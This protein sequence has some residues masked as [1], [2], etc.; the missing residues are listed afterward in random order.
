MALS[1]GVV[2]LIVTPKLNFDPI[3]LPKMVILVTFA[4]GLTAFVFRSV[5]QDRSAFR[6]IEFRLIGLLVLTLFLAFNFTSTHWSLQLWGT[7]GR[8]TGLLT[9]LALLTYSLFA[10]L[11]INTNNIGIVIKIFIRTS[12]IFSIYV[13]LQY[14]ELDPVAWSVNAPVGTLGNINFMSSFL[15]LAS[16]ALTSKLLIFFD[17]LSWSSR[18]HYILWTTLNLIL[19]YSSG[20]IQG[21]AMFMTGLTFLIFLI[22]MRKGNKRIA[23]GVLILSTFSGVLGFLGTLGRGLFGEELQQDSVLFRLDYWKAALRMILDYPLI[24]IGLDG[25]GEFYREYRD[26]VAVNRT[27]PQR[28]TDTAHNVFL[29]LATGGGLLVLTPFVLLIFL[30]SWRVLRFSLSFHS[31]RSDALSLAPLLSGWFVFML[32]SINQ[33]GVGVWGFIFLGASL[34]V[35]RASIGDNRNVKKAKNKVSKIQSTNY[36][37]LLKNKNPSSN[38]ESRLNLNYSVSIMVVSFVTVSVFGL[39]A[40][41]PPLISDFRFNNA[42]KSK[43]VD[44]AI[45]LVNMPPSTIPQVE[46]VLQTLT[47]LGREKEAVHVARKALKRFP[48]NF[49]TNVVLALSESSAKS[50]AARARALLLDIDPQNLELRKTLEDFENTHSRP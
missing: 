41:L 9:Y 47:D 18:I 29:D 35:S 39:M 37:K 45:T 19:I 3:N 11:F 48:R 6:A 27:G 16:I 26:S 25:Y 2:T 13:L 49:R 15:G 23:F 33:I 28:V 32:I 34:G 8:N 43:S 22:L 24:G 36:V 17:R 42:L 14:A 50:E 30:A 31:P 44:A 40:C 5:L 7:G 4:A 12:Y 38:G 1:A 10:L 20:S 46:I 21:L